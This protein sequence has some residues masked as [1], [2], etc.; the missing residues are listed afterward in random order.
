MSRMKHYSKSKGG[1]S[2]WKK[3]AKWYKG[4]ES[5]ATLANRIP[6]VITTNKLTVNSYFGASLHMDDV[7]KALQ[8]LEHLETPYNTIMAKINFL[9]N[10]E[11]KTTKL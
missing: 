6:Q 2:S 7:S 10:I 4:Q 1:S 11:E 3:V 8:H 5:T 9:N